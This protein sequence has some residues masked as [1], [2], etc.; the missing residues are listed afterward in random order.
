[1]LKHFRINHLGMIGKELLIFRIDVKNKFLYQPFISRVYIILNLVV[2]T[3]LC[4]EWY[5][6]SYF[7]YFS[8][9]RNSNLSKTVNNNMC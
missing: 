3:T 5:F 9:F 7:I 6:V 2:S 1:M 8:N 4:F